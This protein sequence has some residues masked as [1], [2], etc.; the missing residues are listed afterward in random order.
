MKKLQVPTSEEDVFLSH[1]RRQSFSA[2]KSSVNSKKKVDKTAWERLAPA[3]L[4]MRLFSLESFESAVHG[5]TRKT[6]LYSLK[7]SKQ[8]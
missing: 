6:T 1:L 8:F 4:A 5:P 2:V 7:N 3:S